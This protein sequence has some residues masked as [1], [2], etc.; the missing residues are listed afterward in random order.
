MQNFAPG[1]EHV[2]RNVALDGQPQNHKGKKRKIQVRAAPLPVA[3]APAAPP[4]EKGIHALITIVLNP[5]V[6]VG[7]AEEEI[8]IFDPPLEV[9][10][11]YTESDVKATTLNPKGVPQ[12][13]LT[14]GYP[15][16]QGWKWERLE[17][18]VTPSSKTTGTLHAKIHA[19]RP[20]D[21]V[22]ISRP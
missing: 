18:E 17:T 6:T 7:D 8:E 15:T 20:K 3:V 2:T 19:L 13:S 11:D 5:V 4:R 22:W 16:E 1:R 9:H 12:L 21:P 14:L 10:V